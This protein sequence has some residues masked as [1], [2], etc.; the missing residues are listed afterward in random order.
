VGGRERLDGEPLTSEATFTRYA[1]AMRSRW[2]PV[3]RWTLKLAISLFSGVIVTWGVAWG[4]ALW[5]N[6]GA[7][8]TFQ[9]QLGAQWVRVDLSTSFLE[10]RWEVTAANSADPSWVVES[11]PSWV[12]RPTE[13]DLFTVST[14]YGVPFRS[15]FETAA[16]RDVPGKVTSGP[17]T[18]TGPRVFQMD[19][20]IDG[21]NLESG[22]PRETL[23]V[24]I[25]TIAFTLNALLTAGV[26]F[27]AME[28][29]ALARRRMRHRKGRCTACGYDRGGLTV[30][31][32]CPECG[33]KV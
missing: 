7:R 33:R 27:I 3:K 4:C 8:R 32:A 20:M 15:L 14:A 1:R 9:S 11:V 10:E 28:G 21:I 26:A 19:W 30:D 25:L 5:R 17:L 16:A 6:V 24:R 12:R 18:G 31:V 13:L 29:T 23:P 22:P 2:S